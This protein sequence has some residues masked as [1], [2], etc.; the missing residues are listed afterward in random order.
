VKKILLALLFMGF[1]SLADSQTLQTL[2]SFNGTNGANP[3][4]ALTL[5]SDGN[6]YGTTATGGTYGDGTV[7]QIT[8]N[9]V[10]TTLFSFNNNIEVQPSALTEGNDGNFYGTTLNGGDN[11]YGTIFQITT[12]G[13]LTTLTNFD[14]YNGFESKAPL[15]LGND[16]N[17]YGTTESGGADNSGTVFQVTTNGTLTTLFSFIYYDVTNGYNPTAALTLGNDG[18]FYGST[19]QGGYGGYGTIFKITTNGIL[20][21]LVY[22][23]YT[24]GWGANTLAIGN[25]GN[26][27]GTTYQGQSTVFELTTNY[28]FIPLSGGATKSALTLGED[29]SFYGT[30]ASGAGSVFQVTTNGTQTGLYGFSGPD[31][32]QP[33]ATVTVGKD[34]SLYGTTEFGGDYNAGTVFRLMLSPVITAQPQSQTNLVGTTVIFFANITGLNPLS[35]QWQ[36]NGTNLV[37]ADNVSGVNSNTLTIAD[38]LVSDGG[39]YSV[40]VS[41]FYGVVTSSN[42]TLTVIIPPPTLA[43]QFLA[44]YPLLSLYGTLGEIYT[45]EYTTNLAVPNWTPMLIVPNLSI[46]PFLMIDPA[47]IVPPTRFYRAVMQ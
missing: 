3:A 9:G 36:K 40:I 15:T 38:I 7:F 11:N 46:S 35:Y 45:V 47:G 12:N 1:T 28:T 21:T 42:A 18:N 43:L 20:T 33:Q 30:T 37:N 10:L 24:N 2:V 22:F 29:G 39:S 19:S 5:G 26:F 14:F 41:N 25:D 4:V 32:F 6:F 31:G 13:T 17:F 8:T 34:G 23:N 44:G 27:Y 16:G